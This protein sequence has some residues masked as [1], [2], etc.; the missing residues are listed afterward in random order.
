MDCEGVL[1]DGV[2]G[3]HIHITRLKACDWCESVCR[4]ELIL[5]CLNDSITSGIRT[6]IVLLELDS[7]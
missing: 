2:N 6:A 5:I 1:I 4:L 3:Y 7:K